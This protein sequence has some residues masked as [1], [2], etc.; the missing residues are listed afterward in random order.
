MN[1]RNRIPTYRPEDYIQGRPL[2]TRFFSTI[3]RLGTKDC[4]GNP[5]NEAQAVTYGHRRVAAIVGLSVFSLLTIVSGYKVGNM[6]ADSMSD[7]DKHQDKIEECTS[8]LVGYSVELN[9]DA[10]GN[11]PV[12][13]DV[14]EEVEGCRTA[15]GNADEARDILYG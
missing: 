7:A 9:T 4:L 13:S 2:R 12:P 6:L 15:G 14:A 1:S 3:G 11:I 5:I 10:S 8:E